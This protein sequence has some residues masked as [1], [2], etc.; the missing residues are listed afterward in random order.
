LLEGSFSFAENQD[1]PLP[2]MPEVLTYATDKWLLAACNDWGRLGVRNHLDTLAPNLYVSPNERILVVGTGEFVWRPFLLAERLE[3]MGALVQFGS[4]TRSP[5]TLGHAI[6][7]AL[8][9]GDNYGLGI[10]NFIYNVRPGQFD[11][12][13]ICCETP[14]QSVDPRL[15]EALSAEVI[16]DVF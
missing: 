11:R 3:K 16:S 1:A 15:V 13:I 5:I 4:T 7:H 2:E 10:P 9:F 14:T 8:C 6:G 12:V